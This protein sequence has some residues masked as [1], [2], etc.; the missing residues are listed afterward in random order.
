[1]I[2]RIL[3]LLNSGRVEVVQARISEWG[4]CDYNEK[5]LYVRKTLSDNNRVTT[6][7]HECIHFLNPDFKERKVLALEKVVYNNLSKTEHK[8]VLSFLK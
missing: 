2:K 7:V 5:V 4:L 3:K 6:L 1:M 8:Q